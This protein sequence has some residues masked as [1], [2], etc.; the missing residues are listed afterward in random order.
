MMMERDSLCRKDSIMQLRKI[1][2]LIF[3]AGV[4]FVFMREAQAV[5]YRDLGIEERSR[6]LQRVIKPQE[7]GESQTTDDKAFELEKERIAKQLTIITG[8][9]DTKAIIVAG[10]TLH[11]KFMDR[12]KEV[13]NIY[14]VNPQGEIVMPLIGAVKVVDLNRGQ[15][16]ALLNERMQEYIR[17]P[18]LA[19]DINAEGKYTI[20]GAAGPGVYKLESDLHVMEAILKAGYEETRANLG[21]VLL[22]RGS[23]EKPVIIKLNLKKMIK[24]GD[25]SDDLALK[26]DDIIYV[27]DTLLYNFDTFKDKM[28]KYILDYYTLG[29][30]TLIQEK[31]KRDNVDENN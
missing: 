7:S 2:M 22:M 12:G 10:D 30:S 16:R 11:I 8:D 4:L 13:S 27:P 24:K 25:R 15:A 21:H 3:W 17:A 6:Q 31:Q 20:L 1:F 28:F 18:Q 19:M 9:E 14:K 5:D 29:G 23:R 26:P